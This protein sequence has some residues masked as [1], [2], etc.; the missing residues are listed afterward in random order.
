MSAVYIA[1]S[2]RLAARKVD[3]EMIILS[4]DDSSLY[5]LNEVGTAI[6]EAADGKTTLA[7]IVHG[8][9]CGRYD[10]DS[11]TGLNDAREFVERLVRQRILE[12]STEPAA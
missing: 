12:V 10:V 5:V 4:A 9:I 6:W 7:S 11:E 1:R 8:V 2:P 3:G